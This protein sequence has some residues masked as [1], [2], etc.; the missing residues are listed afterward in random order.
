MDLKIL[1]QQ[2]YLWLNEINPIAVVLCIMAFFLVYLGVRVVSLIH[3]NKDLEQA[4]E[5]QTALNR[6]NIQLIANWKSRCLELQ[7]IISRKKQHR[8]K[9][10]TFCSEQQYLD[11]LNGVNL[12]AKTQ[13]ELDA[14]EIND[15]CNRQID[16]YLKK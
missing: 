11:E 10:G 13:E 4:L 1:F 8:L 5:D 14:I 12:V 6:G 15:E 2:A 7:D 16:E 3:A 9:D